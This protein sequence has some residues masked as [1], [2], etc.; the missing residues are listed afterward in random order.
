[1]L[2]EPG[3]ALAGAMALAERITANGPL[4]VAVTKEIIAKSAGWSE[5]EMWKKQSELIMPVFSSKDAMEG[6]TAFAEKRA[7]NWTGT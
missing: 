2:T 1:M 3:E 5:D 4:A 7:P 6:A